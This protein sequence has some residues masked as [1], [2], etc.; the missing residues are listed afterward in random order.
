[1]WLILGPSLVVVGLALVTQAVALGL[2]LLALG[3]VGLVIS[4][5]GRMS[6]RCD[7]TGIRRRQLSTRFYPREEISTLAVKPVAG[8]GASR[9][10]IE[11]RLKDGTRVP[12]DATL[13]VRSGPD[14]AE[15]KA[16]IAEMQ[17]ILGMQAGL[18]G[19]PHYQG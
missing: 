5:L 18:E 11:L 19:L 17:S 3:A 14:H 2:M 8:I 13:V 12:L 15:L 16:Q 4:R 9:A 6:V 10:E 1:M 7:A